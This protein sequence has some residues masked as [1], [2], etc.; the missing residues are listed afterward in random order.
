MPTIAEYSLGGETPAGL[1]PRAL[2]GDVFVLRGA[3]Q[4]YGLLDQICKA[5]LE[6]ISESV[7]PTAADRARDDGFH[8]IHE[9][10]APTDIPRMTDA[11][12]NAIRPLAPQLLRSFVAKAFP[13][14]DTLYYEETPNVRFH[15]PYD[16]ARAQRES[17][18]SFT[19]DYGEGK[20]TAHGPH[21]DSWLDCPSNGVNLWFAIGRVQKGNGLTIYADDYARDFQYQRSGDISDGEKLHAP[22]TF[23]LAPGDGIMFH[24]DHSAWIRAEPYR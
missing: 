4:A 24:T 8:R 7:G 9:W 6:A 20:I 17:Y 15:I 2:G 11:V 10:V 19:K 1:V 16:L 12:Y 14:A 22:Q 18:K 5:S 23:D 21:R 13:D 3:L